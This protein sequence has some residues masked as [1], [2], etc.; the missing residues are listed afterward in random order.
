MTTD[1]VL[2]AETVLRLA[3]DRLTTPQPGQCLAC[4]VAA[5]LEQYGCDGTLRFSL[6]YR[7]VTAPRAVALVS[8]LDRVGAFCDCELFLNGYEL[9]DEDTDRPAYCLA[10]RKGSVTPCALWRRQRRG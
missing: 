1:V 10:V 9:P 6:R 7:D 4:F 2:E 8:R 3:A 5:A